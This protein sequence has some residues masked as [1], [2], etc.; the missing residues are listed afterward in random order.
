MAEG[1][2]VA[3]AAP[4]A[5]VNPYNPIRVDL[6]QKVADPGESA[7][8]E[9]RESFALQT[10][11]REIVEEAGAEPNRGTP[12]V[13]AALAE[14]GLQFGRKPTADE[15]IQTKLRDPHIDIGPTLD[16]QKDTAMYLVPLEPIP[17][18]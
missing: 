3:E 4:S 7:T 8:P 16:P 1:G 10:R 11:V 15:R 9:Q 17:P 18:K 14:M 12:Y 13:E 5:P 6:S 2:I